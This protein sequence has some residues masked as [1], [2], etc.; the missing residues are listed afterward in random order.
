MTTRKKTEKQSR[1]RYPDEYKTEAVKLAQQVGTT[2]AA[3]ELGIQ[4]SQI[5]SWRSQRRVQE[6]TTDTENRLL[7]E[8]AKLKRELA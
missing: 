6:S 1:K 8:N 4:T 2:A 5:Y 3:K 7:S